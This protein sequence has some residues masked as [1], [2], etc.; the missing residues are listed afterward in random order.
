MLELAPIQR[1][2]GEALIRNLKRQGTPSKAH[3]FEIYLDAE[4]QVAL[5]DRY[6]FWDTVQPG[7][8]EGE[9]R[10]I[11]VQRFLGYDYVTWGLSYQ[12]WGFPTKVVEDTAENRRL[13]GRSFSD[14]QRG[15]IQSRADFEAYRWPDPQQADC[16]GLDYLNKNLP[17]DMVL[18]AGLSCHQA[19]FLTWMF[20]YETL[21]YMLADDRELVGAVAQKLHEYFVGVFRIYCSYERVAAAWAT[22]DMGFRTGTLIAPDDLREFVLPTHK[23]CAEIAHAQDKLYLLHCCGNIRTLMEDF[24]ED[25]RIDAKHSFEDT[26]ESVIDAKKEYGDRIALLGG[27]DVDF[28]CRCDE[29]SLRTRV[30]ETLDACQPGGGYCLGTGNSVAN[31]IPIDQYLVMLDESRRY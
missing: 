17:N 25:V 23:A 28:L 22:D 3:L 20:G 19:E 18:V 4:I 12:D 14:E 2:D 8:H 29:A 26:I 16:S 1:I 13:G 11:A 6:R 9:R 5:N 15:P 7:P 24:I 27:I 10:A 30:R 31:Y 21:C